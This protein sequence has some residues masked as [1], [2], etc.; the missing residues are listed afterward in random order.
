MT[1]TQTTINYSELATNLAA[2]LSALTGDKWSGSEGLY[3]TSLTLMRESD[4]MVLYGYRDHT[5]KGWLQLSGDVIPFLRTYS[6]K[7]ALMGVTLTRGADTVA[8]DI[9]R[10]LLPAATKQHAE[11]SARRDSHDAYNDRVAQLGER[12]I[13]ASN[14]RLY[15]SDNRLLRWN[16]I[17]E[18]YGNMTVFSDHVNMDIH[19]LSPEL[20]E[21]VL[22]VLM[23]D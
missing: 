10:R 12:M 18:H 13:T 22:A 6:E 1:N 2:S 21:K 23:A 4:A 11:L 8:R 19:N 20:A 5:G 17:N 3:G 9:V 15:Y 7:A 16:G 14:G